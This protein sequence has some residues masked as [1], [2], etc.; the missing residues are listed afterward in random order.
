MFFV[1]SW[2]HPSITRHVAEGLLMA[3]GQDGSYLL[4]ASKKGQYSLSVR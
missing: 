3:N 4:R 1:Y 2:F